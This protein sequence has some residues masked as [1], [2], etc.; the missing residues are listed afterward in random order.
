LV[1]V[2]V[3]DLGA[4]RN[5]DVEVGA[6][7]TGHV[8]PAAGLAVRGLEAPLHAEVCERVEPLARHEIDA[9]AAAAVAAVRPAPRDELLAAKAD[10]AVAAATGLDANLR[11]V[12][13]FHGR[14]GRR[15]PRAGAA[16]PRTGGRENAV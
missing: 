4:D 15:A 3:P 5:G 7:L 12:D 6:G 2:E 11:F 14:T 9:A 1:G 8:A 10:R 13:E 16:C